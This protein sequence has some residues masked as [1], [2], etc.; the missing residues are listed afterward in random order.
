MT[1]A[2]DRGRAGMMRMTRSPVIDPSRACGGFNRTTR[3]THHI[4]SKPLICHAPKFQ[5]LPAISEGWPLK[6][7][8][9]RR[10][11]IFPV[12]VGAGIKAREEVCPGLPAAAPFRGRLMAAENRRGA[13]PFRCPL[14]AATE[15]LSAQRRQICYVLQRDI[16]WRPL[17]SHTQPPIQGIETW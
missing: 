12:G 11:E 5:K 1:P 9:P 7:G 14:Q 2:I 13:V 6:L 15:E 16:R 3:H 17:A 4:W 10:L 8:H